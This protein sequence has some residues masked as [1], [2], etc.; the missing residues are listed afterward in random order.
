MGVEQLQRHLAAMNQVLGQIDRRHP[1]TTQLTNELKPLRFST[2]CCHLLYPHQSPSP[3]MR[4][5]THNLHTRGV[6]SWDFGD[7]SG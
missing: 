5:P 1:T 7:N 3:V 4:P 2:D 6:L